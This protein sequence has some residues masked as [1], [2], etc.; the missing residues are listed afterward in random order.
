MVPKFLSPSEKKKLNT[1]ISRI[2]EDLSKEF[3]EDQTFLQE[4]IS[5]YLSK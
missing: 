3:S 2:I 1:F 4:I 5:F